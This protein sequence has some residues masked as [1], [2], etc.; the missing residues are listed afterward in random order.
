MTRVPPNS[1]LFPYPTLVRSEAGHVAGAVHV[2]PH[3]QRE[4][5]EQVADLLQGADRRDPAAGHD[6][7]V[8]RQLLQGFGLVAGDEQALPPIRRANACNPVTVQTRMPSS[9]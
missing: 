3:R 4:V 8:A 7:D 6:G 1:A 2:D 5:V 9:S